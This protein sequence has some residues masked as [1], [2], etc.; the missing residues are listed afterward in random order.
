[1]PSVTNGSTETINMGKK[2]SRKRGRPPKRDRTTANTAGFEAGIDYVL[3]LIGVGEE[4]W[5]AYAV[6]LQDRGFAIPPQERRP[7]PPAPKP[8][9]KDATQWVRCNMHAVGWDK[10]PDLP[11]HI[12]SFAVAHGPKLERKIYPLRQLTMWADFFASEIVHAKLTKE[13]GLGIYASTCMQSGVE[14][15]RLVVDVWMQNTR[16]QTMGWDGGWLG[17]AA[18]VNAACIKHSNARFAETNVPGDK[19]DEVAVVLTKTVQGGAQILV[20]YTQCGVRMHCPTCSC[21]LT[22][23][24]TDWDAAERKRLCVEIRRDR[25]VIE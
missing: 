6:E 10:R 20:P 1:M 17:P 7:H 4:E 2:S 5:S 14:V 22:E 8:I 25:S 15:A 13:H 24:S 11:L 3:S 18:L 21:L 23:R 16:C 19:E 12:K 9:Y